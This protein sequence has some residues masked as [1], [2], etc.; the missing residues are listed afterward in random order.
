MLTSLFLL[1]YYYCIEALQAELIKPFNYIGWCIISSGVGYRTDNN[2][3]VREAFF[4][5]VTGNWII[6]REAKTKKPATLAIVLKQL[7]WQTN[8]FWVVTF[9]L[10]IKKHQILFK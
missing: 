1:L 7:Y 8:A 5:A 6:Q 3:Q 2:R 10:L 4:W 9:I